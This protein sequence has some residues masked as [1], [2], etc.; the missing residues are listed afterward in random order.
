METTRQEHT[1]GIIYSCSGKSYIDEA[2]VSA[3]SSLRYN[4]LPHVLFAS[5]KSAQAIVGEPALSI[6]PFKPSGDPYLDKI[7]NI[8]RSPFQRSIFLDTDTFVLGQIVPVLHL[9][10][11][12]DLAA[13]LAPGYRGLQDPDVPEAFYELNSGFIAFRACE[14]VAS[15]L[16]DWQETYATWRARPPFENAGFGDDQ[17]PFRHCAWV[18]GLHVI[19]LG[20][21]Y[22]YRTPV[23]GT[24]VDS[25]R[26]IHGRVDYDRVAAKLNEQSGPR[27]FPAYRPPAALPGRFLDTV[28]RHTPRR[29]KRWVRT[30]LLPKFTVPFI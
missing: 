17:P 9:L 23:P 22:N 18:R 19:V 10:D 11:T 2:L 24:V 25:V 8:R 5:V 16:A 30:H 3:R 20:P 26:V 29:L 14:R 6:V 28:R 15:F 21:E 7:S 1:A 13:C 4:P 12:Y 27:S